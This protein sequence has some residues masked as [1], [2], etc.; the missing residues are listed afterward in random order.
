MT[1][2]VV[3]TGDVADDLRRREFLAFEQ[4]AAVYS[5]NMAEFGRPARA[6]LLE[7][8]ELAEGCSLLDVC[9]GPGWLPLEG[10][11]RCRGGRVLGTD[12]SAAM[13]AEARR[14]AAGAECD[15]VEFAVMDAQQL[16]L[17]D[18]SFDRI[19]CG[20]GLMHLPD[21][22]AALSEMARVA[23]VGGRVVLSVWGGPEETYF[24]PLAAA[25]RAVAGD[26]LP[27]DYGYVTRLG[28]PGV[29]E[30]LLSESGW[31]EPRLERFDSGAVVPNVDIVWAGMSAGTTFGTLVAELPPPE[32]DEV[33]REFTEQ[34]EQFRRPDG[35]HL[36][37]VQLVASAAR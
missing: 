1:I 10:A 34:C 23:R 5:T 26:R 35:I 19:T 14:N 18:R 28:Q 15:D 27:L 29:L 12:L 7:L 16:E 25:L 36:P 21:P 32:R 33:R 37:A 17:P 9:T 20:L 4:G 13:I 2:D 8:A 30:S 11:G 22:G 6:R 24:G 3:L 31:R